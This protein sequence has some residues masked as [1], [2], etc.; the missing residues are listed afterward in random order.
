MA[1]CKNDFLCTLPPSPPI[2]CYLYH[3]CS[4]HWEGVFSLFSATLCPQCLC[5]FLVCHHEN[6]HEQKDGCPSKVVRAYL[7]VQ[8]VRQLAALNFQDEG[9]VGQVHCHN[10]HQSP[11]HLGVAGGRDEMET[12]YRGAQ[13]PYWLLSE[14]SCVHLCGD[15]SRV[16]SD[17][18]IK[19]IDCQSKWLAKC[20]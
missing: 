18:R 10:D 6:L 9:A 8:G 13:S 1:S 4:P 20:M 17:E 7:A 11:F 15:Q 2:H 12:L 14:V 19:W 16:D 5:P 3:E